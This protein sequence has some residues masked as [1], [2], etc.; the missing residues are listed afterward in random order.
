MR[1]VAEHSAGRPKSAGCQPAQP[2][3]ANV[4]RH[5]VEARSGNNPRQATARANSHVV[6]GSHVPS[7][8][9]PSAPDPI[10]FIAESTAGQIGKEFL[11]ALVRSMH[12]AM[13]VSVAVITR[14]VGEPPV[15]A[16]ASF[17]WK[18]S[19]A[20]S[21]TSTIWRARPANWCT[22]GS[23]HRARAAVASSRARWGTK[24]IAGCR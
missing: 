23:A 19:G 18:K 3:N 8:E 7:R 11:T 1:T 16:R 17:S 10:Y 13:D 4:A 24:A 6:S 5:C 14:G 2:A 12:E 9:S 15:K 21:P 20:S 22:A